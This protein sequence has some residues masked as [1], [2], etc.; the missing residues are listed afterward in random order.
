[1][2]T[3][4][5][6]DFCG[7]V[8]LH[9]TNLLQPHG[10]LLVVDG[11]LNIIQ[12]SENVEELVGKPAK[13]L[14]N[15][16]LQD[17]IKPIQVQKIKERL[18][19]KISGRLP[20]LF[21]F[22]SGDHLAIIKKQEA[23]FIMEVEKQNRSSQG[24]DAF[25]TVYEDL[26]YVMAA[27]EEAKTTE[28]TCRIAIEELKNISGFDKIMLYRFDE[29]W[30]GDVIAEVKEEGMDSYLGLKFPA[31]DIPQ[32]ARALYKKT[33]YRLIPD[34]NYEPV[35]LYPVIN[36]V[37]NGFTDLTDSNLRSV[38]AVHIEYLR[39][40]NVVASMSTRILKNGQ[41]W[42]LI[43]CHHRT[44]KHL[45]F[46]LCSVFELLSNVLSAKISAMQN[47]DVFDYKIGMQ[48]VQAHVVES[49][50][51]E[52]S[53]ITALEKNEKSLLELL[54]ADGVAIV[55]NKNVERFG[56]LPTQGAI[57]DL[58]YWLQSKNTHKTYHEPRLSSI[59]E[60]AESYAQIASGV[61][62]LPIQPDK[63]NFI[64][65]FRPE[66]VSKVNWGGNPNET[67]HFEDDKKKYHPR[68][69]FNL[70]QQQVNKT[71]VPWKQEEIE[72]ADSFRHSVM[73]FTLNKMYN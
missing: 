50:Y 60:P 39:N 15:T 63:G 24:N 42:G 25:I 62:V 9:Q 27:I 61:L 7:K 18:N 69:S 8:P 36:P 31:S 34:I 45:S 40:M 1:M 65:A 46:E 29:E 66:A 3:N 68:A 12:V 49:I 21:S 70:W 38:A 23:Y 17:Y 67:V 2:L 22:S 33:P 35:K 19:A 64:L 54:S 43:A 41:L 28:E 32:Q 59:Y 72:V 58:V 55:L 37:T 73:E 52:M 48:Q 26:K 30:N 44:A 6:S 71:A 10:Y 57:E 53:L 11:Q 5:Q 14:I 20:F 47:Q 13:D 16:S 56:T 4:N 51:K